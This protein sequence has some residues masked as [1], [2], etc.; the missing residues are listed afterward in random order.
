MRD[1]VL[2][3]QAAQRFQLAAALGEGAVVLV[4]YRGDW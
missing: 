1:F 4:F 3:D 2:D